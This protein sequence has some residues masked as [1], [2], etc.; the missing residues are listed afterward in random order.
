MEKYFDSRLNQD[1]RK[2]AADVWRLVAE[3]VVQLTGTAPRSVLDLGAGYGDFINQVKAEDKWA[4]DQWPRFREHLNTDVKGIVGDIRE[5][6]PGLPTGHFDLVFMSNVLEHFSIEDAEKILGNARKCLRPGG[7]V[8][9]LQPNFTYC[10][11]H[12]FDD[13]THKTIFTAE[14]LGCFV[15]D[16]GFEPI[17]MK[18]RYL[19]FSF[20]SRLPRPLWAVKLYLRLPIKPLGAQMLFIGQQRVNPHVEKPNH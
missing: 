19:P 11:R 7:A 1:F 9:L 6:V 10:S 17:V 14:G 4:V 2:G 13:Y 20:K 18:P 12:Y 3:H 5:T 15:A 8:A 16:Q